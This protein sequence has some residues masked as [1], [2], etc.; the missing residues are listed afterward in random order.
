[1]PVERVVLAVTKPPERPVVVVLRALGLGD[2]LT[3]VPAL[4]A[5]RRGLPGHELVLL[6]PH[7]FAGL[8][9]HAAL[10]DRVVPIDATTTLPASLPPSPGPCD[11]AV[12][13]HGRGP[14]SHRLLMALHP[15]RLVAFAC[16][17]VVVDGPLWRPG[18]H[19]VERWVRLVSAAGFGAD[20]ADLRIQPPDR[21]IAGLAR[22]ATILH[23][24]AAAPARRWPV[25]RWVQ[26]AIAE[27][28]SGRDVVVTAGPGERSLAER[29]VVAARLPPSRAIVLD[30]ML[31]LVSIVAAA[32]RV[33]CGDTGVAH[34][35]TAV[36]TP[37]VVL[38]GPIPPHEW[39]P[40]TSTI[41]RVLWHGRRGDPHA[42][43]AD[44]GLLTISV[45]EVRR[46]VSTLPP[47]GRCA[48][49]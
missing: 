40:P 1:M 4:R 34:V 48:M 43:V 45:A 44:P 33:V 9:R 30:D 8:V 3:A 19:E 35:A 37:S 10:A 17:D 16:R 47:S 11:V 41:H 24:G 18:E 21:P 29:V 6:T 2:L 42:A 27:Q 12:N 49:T 22:G 36:G 38:F 25:E 23:P 39:G 20:S 14:V 32:A 28:A 7:R 31:D 26:L 5:V 46:A 15:S 13:L